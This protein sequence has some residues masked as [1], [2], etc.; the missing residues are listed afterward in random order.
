[1][2]DPRK[3]YPLDIS[4]F[5]P[6]IVHAVDECKA[7]NWLSCSAL[8]SDYSGQCARAIKAML[9]DQREAAIRE[10]VGVIENLGY[11]A[12]IDRAVEAV[13]ALLL[14]KTKEVEVGDTVLIDRFGNIAMRGPTIPKDM[15]ERMIGTEKA[16][17]AI[18]RLSAKAQVP[19]D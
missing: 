1:M 13:E 16:P 15:P 12:Q 17:Y 19:A 2:A 14:P 18:V 11:S 9:K 3:I 7:L 8:P 4:E 5:A 10:C 6:S